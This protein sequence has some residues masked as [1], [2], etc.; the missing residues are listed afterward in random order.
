[1]MYDYAFEAKIFLTVIKNMEMS[2]FYTNQ[3]R[4]LVLFFTHP[5]ICLKKKKKKQQ[6]K[7]P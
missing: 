5:K 6:Q 1:M 7:K 2:F 4:C 3:K